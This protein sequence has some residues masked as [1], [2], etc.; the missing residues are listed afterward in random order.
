MKAYLQKLRRQIAADTKKVVLLLVTVILG[1]LLWQRLLLKGVPRTA[2]AKPATIQKITLGDGSNNNER[3]DAELAVH[4]I[5]Y[6]YFPHVLYRDLFKV[7]TAG[8]VQVVPRAPA[9]QGKANLTDQ[10][11][12]K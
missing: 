3:E 7:D 8:Y 2:S 1:L 4:P 9:R 12:D 11:A 5:V 10:I 6:I